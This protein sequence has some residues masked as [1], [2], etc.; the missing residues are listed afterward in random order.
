MSAQR[1]SGG[2]GYRVYFFDQLLTME[3]IM[4]DQ[5]G[6]NLNRTYLRDEQAMNKLATRTARVPTGRN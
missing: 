1:D 4:Y 3:L 2:S 5:A 6:S